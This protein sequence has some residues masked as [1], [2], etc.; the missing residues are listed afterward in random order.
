MKNLN[1]HTRTVKELKEIAKEMGLKGYSKMRKQEVWDLIEAEV[2]RI[3]EE[4]T[5]AS[6]RLNEK[7]KEFIAKADTANEAD[8]YDEA[9]NI[10]DENGNRVFKLKFLPVEAYVEE[11]VEPVKN[12]YTKI[13]E[14]E[15]KLKS[16]DDALEKCTTPWDADALEIKL[17]ETYSEYMKLIKIRDE[18]K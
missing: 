7:V 6:E 11:V 17:E 2:E 9:G 1:F 14:L 18:Q 8:N 4:G 10:L 15:K 3:A 16:I 12:L 5:K 13:N